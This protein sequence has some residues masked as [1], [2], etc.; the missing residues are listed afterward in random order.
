[1]RVAAAKNL[2]SQPLE[3]FH[4]AAQVNSSPVWVCCGAG[5]TQSFRW[6]L[7][8]TF[9]PSLRLDSGG[10]GLSC[11][12]C[13]RFVQGFSAL[14]EIGLELNRLVVGEGGAAWA[15]CAPMQLGLSPT[16]R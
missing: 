5:S 9:P 16:T 4:G 15:V 13:E 8:D 7:V 12:M 6:L 10:L 3:P 14:R 1:M 11:D 2:K